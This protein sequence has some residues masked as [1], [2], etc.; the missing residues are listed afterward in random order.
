MPMRLSQILLVS[1]IGLFIVYAARL[2][3]A[4]R[5][6]LAYICLATIGLGLVLNPELTTVVAQRLGIGRGADL[7]FY[8]FIVFCLFHFASTGATIRR[9]QADRTALTQALAL[10]LAQQPAADTAGES[11]T[12]QAAPEGS[13]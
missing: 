7:V 11:A 9:L 5:D 10:H 4:T 1:L 8:V 13:R 6:R 2:R 3:N 12:A